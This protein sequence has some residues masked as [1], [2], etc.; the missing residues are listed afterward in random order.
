MST[1]HSKKIYI[2][3]SGIVSSFGIGLDAIKEGLT[4]APVMTSFKDFEFH[5][6]DA[7]IPCIT[8]N[9]YDPVEILGKKGLRLKD[10]ATKLILGA[11]EL[12]L[13]T[14]MEGADDNNRPG[15][16]VGT[17]FGSV[18]SI[19]DF[20]SDSIV[21]G[22]GVVNPQ[23]F[24]NTV[25]NSPTGNTNIRF[26]ARN[27]SST[28]STGF[29]ASI[30][31]LI[32]AFNYMQRGYIEAI[33]AGGLEEISY[34]S[35]LG[36]QRT[37]VL[38]LSGKIKPF[39][40]DADGIVP[41]EGCALFLFDTEESMKANGRAPIVEIVGTASAFD[42]SLAQNAS[43]DGEAAAH[44][45]SEVCKDAGIA[46][47]D[48]DFI[49][50]SANGNR[51]TDSVEAAA[52]TKVFGTSVP[53]AAYKSFTGECYGASGALSL[54]CA[55]SDLKNKQISGIGEASSRFKN[56]ALVTAPVKKDSKYCI[57]NSV[58]C[59]GNCSAVLLKNVE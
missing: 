22:V 48:V 16:C 5:S 42:V 30:D 38:S 36:L 8:V 41:G 56:I 23:A 44:V 14:V 40:T 39:A 45:L 2:T 19:G 37:G 32:Y 58:S 35:I 52:I 46:P 26:V 7:E 15:I 9:G 33:V 10:H 51:L 4:K 27:L 57:V 12:G 17:A 53:V 55:I 1:M 18:Q 59:D 31:A 25:I 11:F 21:N 47:K 6:L 29:N 43:S 28:I 49:A 3:S 34:Y 24:A 54:A 50:S 13:K 20:L